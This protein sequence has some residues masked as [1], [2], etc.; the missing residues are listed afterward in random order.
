MIPFSATAIAMVAAAMIVARI[1]GQTHQAHEK[2]AIVR[3]VGDGVSWLWKHP[4]VRALAVTIFVFNVTYGAAFS[5]YVLLA[6]ERLGLTDAGFGLLLSAPAVGGVVASAVYPALERRFSLANLMR[7][8]FAIETLTHL[9][10]ATSTLPVVTG[11]TMTV[12]GAH[13]LVWNTTSTTVRQ[14]AVPS[15]LLGRVM[16]VH[17]MA[18]RGGLVI[19][20]LVGGLLAWQ[21]GLTAPFWFGFVGS[22]F[23]LILIWRTLGDIAH[24]PIR[25]QRA[26]GS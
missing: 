22:A 10:L 19:G 4:P 12:F 6:K 25:A 2:P 9:V 16:S 17:M 13:T 24:A 11:I 1:A 21:L 3:E 18:N 26:G 5:V 23:L 20:A 14:R 8:G 15:A 7:G